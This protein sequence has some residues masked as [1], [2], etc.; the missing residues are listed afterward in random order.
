MTGHLVA[1]DAGLC[2]GLASLRRCLNY[3]WACAVFAV[4]V[5]PRAEQIRGIAVEIGSRITSVTDDRTDESKHNEPDFTVDPGVAGSGAE[6]FLSSR[7]PILSM[8]RVASRR[9]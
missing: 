5:W 1:E 2:D 8:I 3:A 7:Q 9:G 6:D 4:P